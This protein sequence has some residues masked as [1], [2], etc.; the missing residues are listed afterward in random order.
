M[1]RV[2]LAIAMAVV[3]LS[4]TLATAQ[5]VTRVVSPGGIE[6]W[7]IED[8]SNPLIS[9]ELSFR[10]G[11]A[12]DPRDKAGLSALVAG[13]LDEGAG[14]LDSLAYRGRL[15]DL[16]IHMGFSAGR[17][18]FTGSLKTLSRNRDAAF[19]MLRLA[20]SAPRFDPEPLERVRSQSLV[21]LARDRARPERIAARAWFSTVF[22]DH[23]Y[24]VP[25]KGTPDSLAGLTRADLQAYVRD[26]FARDNLVIGVAGDIDAT[27]LAPLL[28]ATFGAL[29]A[30][31]VLP[32]LP[33][34]PPPPPGG[35]TVIARDIPQSS[36]FFGQRGV[37]R[38]DPD[39]YPAYVMNY[40]LG[41]GGFSSR[42][43]EEVRE[44]RGLAYSVYSSL[45][46]F[47]AAPM[48]IGGVASENS[49]I[50]QSIELITAAWRDMRDNGVSAAELDAAKRYLTGSFPLRFTNLDSLAGMLVV[51]Q[52]DDLGLDFLETRNDQ[53]MA[54][55]QADIA[56]VAR[57]VLDPEALVFVVVGQPEGL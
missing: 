29:P 47:D 57:R 55:T 38:D 45:A 3:L 36:A 21:A 51:M 10:G 28:D 34:V 44:K 11:A 17:D 52:T 33:D 39:F 19:E 7:L 4:P 24:G 46:E 1:M 50:A 32:P 26:R 27:E 40:V 53:V 25:R 18:A 9:I 20:L 41:G 56:R 16:S 8:R 5:T 14:S 37:A 22:A 49:R 6:A 31:A 23:P 35:L 48:I 43:T 13:L 15:E 42:L 12:R 2:L 54:V 30:Q